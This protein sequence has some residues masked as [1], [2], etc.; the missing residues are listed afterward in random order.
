AVEVPVPACPEPIIPDEVVEVPPPAEYPV[1]A[2]IEPVPAEFAPIPPVEPVESAESAES[3]ELVE[4][5][6]PWH[7]RVGETVRPAL[8]WIVLGW[9]IGVLALSAWHVRGWMQVQRLRRVGVR[10]VGREITDVL[11]RL[12]KRLGISRAVRAVESALVRVPTVVGCLKPIILL[13]ASALTGLTAEQLEAILAHELAHIRRHD[14]LINLLQ[15]AAETLLFYHPA[16]WWVSRRIRAERENCCD[17]LAVAASGQP[18]VYARALTAV[19]KLSQPQQRLA[20]AAN[21]GGKFIARIRRIVGLPTDKPDR[22]GRWLAGAFTLLTVLTIVITLTVSCATDKTP[23]EKSPATQTAFRSSDTVP[24]QRKIEGRVVNA[25]GKPVADAE[26]LVL[27]MGPHYIGTEYSVE[28]EIVARTQSDADGKFFAV[29]TGIPEEVYLEGVARKRGTGFGYSQT[30]GFPATDGK[31]RRILLRKTAN[32]EGLVVDESGQP[33]AGA[34]VRADLFDGTEC[35]DPDVLGCPHLDW[36]VAK[37]G[38]DGRF[39]IPGVPSDIFAEFIVRADGWG[40]VAT[41]EDI[42]EAPQFRAGQKNIQIVLPPQCRI[43]GVAIDKSTG[44]PVEDVQL[45]ATCG[46]VLDDIAGKPSTTFRPS[47]SLARPPVLTKSDKDGRFVM[48]ALKPGHWTVALAQQRM[49]DRAELG[50]WVAQPV[51]VDLAAKE[52]RSIRVELSRGEIVE[53]ALVDGTGAPVRGRLVI[54]FGKELWG[55]QVSDDNGTVLMRLLPGSYTLMASDY[56]DP[57]VYPGQEA[58]RRLHGRVGLTVEHGKRSQRIQVR[59]VQEPATQPEKKTEKI[60]WGETVK[61]LQS[62]LSFDLQD[63]PYRAGELVSFRLHVRNTGKKDVTLADFVA[64]DPKADHVVLVSWSPS[65]RDSTG[66]LL[67]MSSMTIGMPVRK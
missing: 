65:V 4:P 66:R 2:A 44:K 9:L 40:T 51:V 29:V 64:G 24:T 39:S 50:Q 67:P 26:I 41:R 18:L 22:R 13:P 28:Q 5:P 57:V 47:A 21:G 10:P 16:A 61:G 8:P 19:A 54:T 31:P 7:E 63:R 30:V 27:K 6:Q 34:Q 36:F 59:L 46:H 49:H 53:V 11:A 48:N 60:A 33:I 55:S 45:I 25:D 43:E 52:S 42:R 1:E 38:K 20:V 37:T 56:P 62:G 58:P 23:V 32:L 3:A 35:L 12:C 17:D 14:Y 15:T